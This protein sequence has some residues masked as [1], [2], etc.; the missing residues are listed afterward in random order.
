MICQHY[1]DACIDK[2][3]IDFTKLNYTGSTEYRI[4][5]NVFFIFFRTVA[6]MNLFMN[7]EQEMRNV[8]LLN[9]VIPDYIKFISH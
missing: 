8:L 7:F 5:I 2:F 4:F 6:V 9:V 3:S 1:D